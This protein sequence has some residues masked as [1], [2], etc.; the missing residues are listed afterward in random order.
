MK[1]IVCFIFGLFA[2]TLNCYAQNKDIHLVFVGDI[3]LAEA[4]GK[5]IQAGKNPFA[6]FD[7][8][9]KNADISIGNLECVVGING[10]KEDKPY[11]FLA[12]PRILPVLEKY[13]SAVSLANNH[14]G[15]YGPKTFSTML[16]LLN[17]NGIKSFGGGKDIR[18]AHEPALFKVKG[19]TIAILAYNLFLPRSFEALD[20]R[21]GVA[22]GEDDYV[23]A[24][25]KRAKEFYKADVVITYPHWGW[26]QE[27]YASKEQERVAHLMIDAGADIVIGGHPHV[28]QNIEIYREKPIFYSLGNFVFNGF[29]GD[30][31]NTGW[32]LDIKINQENKPSWNI[33]TA[34]LNNLGIPINMGITQFKNETSL[35]AHH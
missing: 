10:V 19:K 32:A 1:K 12:H 7:Q 34:K 8:L 5:Y 24:D 21:P 15:D 20:D 3:M 22:W 31:Q 33:Y 17:D 23:V 28:T 26:E 18:S 16:D 35:T 27:K 4:P 29:E 14:S 2:I 13:F 9:L 11:T 6:S 25:I 30:D